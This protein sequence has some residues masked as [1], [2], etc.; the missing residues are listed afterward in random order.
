MVN[1][2]LKFSIGE[3]ICKDSKE[4]APKLSYVRGHFRV[5]NDKKV[6]IKPH[7]RKK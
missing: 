4:P 5:V 3:F 7:Y 6:Y 1:I 2:T